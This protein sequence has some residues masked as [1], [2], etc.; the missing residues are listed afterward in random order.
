MDQI[1]MYAQTVELFWGLLMFGIKFSA[2]GLALIL[3]TN[4]IGAY[5]GIEPQDP[6]EIRELG[7]RVLDIFTA[8]VSRKIATPESVT[9]TERFLHAGV[10]AVFTISVTTIFQL[11]TIPTAAGASIAA[12]HLFG[13]TF[14][15][16]AVSLHLVAFS[17]LLALAIFTHANAQ[18][19]EGLRYA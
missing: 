17:M 13:S 15:F 5:C 4:K 1:E 14:N 16:T 11:I 10:V 3:A 7:E 12:A 18:I 19:Q 9:R 2:I 6:E 8:P